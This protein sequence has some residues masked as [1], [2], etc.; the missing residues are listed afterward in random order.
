MSRE[1]DVRTLNRFV[2]SRD[3]FKAMSK[4]LKGLKGDPVEGA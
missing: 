3:E 2:E 1:T 4:R